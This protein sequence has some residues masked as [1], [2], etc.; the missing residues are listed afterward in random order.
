M[1]SKNK[2]SKASFIVLKHKYV[3]VFFYLFLLL[4]FLFAQEVER[5]TAVDFK[6]KIDELNQNDEDF[7]L[8]DIRTLREYQAGYIEGAEQIDFY[9]KDFI[10]NLQQMDKSRTYLIYCRSGNRTSQ[11]LQIMQQLGFEHVIDLKNGII[12]WIDAGFEL[13]E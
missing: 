9:G 4:P 12:S 3:A 11:T 5:Y 10:S 13:I 6:A 8:L 2:S 1:K 7:A